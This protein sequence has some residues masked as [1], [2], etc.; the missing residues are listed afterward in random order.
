[1]TK[2]KKLNKRV[3]NIIKSHMEKEDNE[4]LKWQKSVIKEEYTG[5]D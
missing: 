5:K 4:Q 2:K 1:M 3:L